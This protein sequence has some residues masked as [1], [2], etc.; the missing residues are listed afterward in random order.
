MTSQSAKLPPAN[1][2]P[3]QQPE[4]LA[5]ASLFEHLEELRQRIIFGLMAWLAC[6]MLAF[7]YRLPLLELIQQPLNASQ[8]YQQGQVQVV[9]QNLTD[10]FL[11]SVSLS[12]WAGLALALP[13][14]LAQV[15]L[16]V[17]PALYQRERRYA[18]PFVIGG[19]LAFLGGA[20][21]GYHLVLPTMVGF[22]LDFLNG[23][24]TPL[25]NL[26]DY[27]GTVT[28]F[29]V[30]FGLSF[31][32][33]I[34]AVILTRIQLVNHHMLR[35]IWRFALVGILLFAAILT[36]TPDPMSML[37]VAL[38]L[39]GLYELGILLSRIFAVTSL[40]PDATPSDKDSLI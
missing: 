23:A 1:Q 18:L 4:Q 19:G 5:S 34:L 22:L 25:L 28:A 7:A 9:T 29:L 30:A 38:P 32:M 39:Y 33:P 17:A 2:Q 6:F 31:E 26:R 24:V 40:T 13:F 10:Q 14:L 35:Q 36:P 3:E 27:V 12:F 15:W 11:L 16:F 37:L 21:F 8:L 20:I